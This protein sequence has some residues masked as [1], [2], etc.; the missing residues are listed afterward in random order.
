MKSRIFYFPFSSGV[1]KY[2]ERIRT[3]LG[4]IAD[5]APLSLKE[6]CANLLKL[7]KRKRGVAV[8]NWVENMLVSSNGRFSFYGLL[9]LVFAI[10][11]LKIRFDK[12]IYIQHNFYPHNTKKSDIKR[13]RWCINHLTKFVDITVAHSPHLSDKVYIPHP[14]YRSPMVSFPANN[15]FN[16]DDKSYLIFG[17]IEPYKKIESVIQQFPSNKKLI[18]AGACSD[19]NYA[20][21]L[22]QLVTNK[23]NIVLIARF[24]SDEEVE[25]IISR[26]T[27]I[28]ISHADPDMIVSGSF[29]YAITEQLPVLAISSPFLEWAESELGTE[30]VRTFIGLEKMMSHI[31]MDNAIDRQNRSFS[32]KDINKINQM[33]SDETIF[34]TFSHLLSTMK[35][36]D[37]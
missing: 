35:L 13:V 32:A 26:C 20:K 4:S 5:V 29:F 11:A 15:N 19:N 17:R 16:R 12:V 22:T 3:I 24:L 23:P 21:Y 14:L 9:K 36:K 2:S 28:I 31:Q 25:E 34:K 27:A 18:V 1:N 37:Y 7:R 6:E 30:I 10:I 33:F 8:V